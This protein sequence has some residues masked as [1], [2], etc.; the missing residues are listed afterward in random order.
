MALKHKKL[1]IAV[2]DLEMT[3]TVVILASCVLCIL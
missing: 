3:F 2:S 1:Y